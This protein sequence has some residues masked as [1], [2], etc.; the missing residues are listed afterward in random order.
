MITPKGR[1][2]VMDFGL[3]WSADLTQLTKENTILGT[4]AYM[5]PVQSCGEKV[6]HRTDIWSLGVILYE[7]GTGLKPFSGE[8]EQATIYS[9]LNFEPELPTAHCTEIGDRGYQDL[10]RDFDKAGI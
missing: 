6:D 4:V 10:L 7:M 1:V 2:K 5:S 9:I 3:A 8:Y